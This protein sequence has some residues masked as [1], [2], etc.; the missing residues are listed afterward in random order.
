ME[1]MNAIEMRHVSKKFKVYFDKGPGLKERILFHK[2][3]HYEERDVLNDVSLCIEKGSAV[4]IIGK[5][6]SGKSTMLKILARI[7]YPNEGAVELHGRV[8]SLI[9][10]GAGFHPDLSGRENIYTNASI[11]GLTKREINNRMDEIVKFSELEEFLDNPV[12]TYSSGMYMRLAFSVAINVD[13]DILLIDEILAV[14]D[15]GFQ[16]KCMKKLQDIRKNGTTIVIVS[17]SFAQI[18]QICERSIWLENGKVKADGIC[19]DVHNRYQNEVENKEE[20]KGDPPKFCDAKA[21][22]WGNKKIKF[23]SLSLKNKKGESDVFYTGDRMEIQ[24]GY[25]CLEKGQKANF[26]IA[27]YRNDGL[28]C[29]G[30]HLEIEKGVFASV[31][32]EGV[33]KIVIERLELLQGDY[34]LD[35]GVISKTNE[36]YEEIKNARRFTVKSAKRRLG[37]CNLDVRWDIDGNN[38]N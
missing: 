24:M 2:R 38:M 19:R 29:F 26:G 18:E 21:F 8:S 37:V 32:N 6:G 10:L 30:T 31:R 5:N 16:Q 23:T 1:G 11:F 34:I 22:S 7:I 14:G 4:G 12:R 28:H 33:V 36:V 35:I 3:N 9:E 20:K 15:L 13:A 25:E 17:H 27:I